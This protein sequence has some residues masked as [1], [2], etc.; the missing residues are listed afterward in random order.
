MELATSSDLASVASVA[1]VGRVSYRS[2]R[3]NRRYFLHVRARKRARGVKAVD[4]LR[5]RKN[6]F[7]EATETFASGVSGWLAVVPGLVPELF[8]A[9]NSG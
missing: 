8:A 7:E 9:I 5:S 2:N 6:H 4:F 1:S 3:R